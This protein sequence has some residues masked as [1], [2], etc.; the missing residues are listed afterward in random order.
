MTDSLGFTNFRIAKTILLPDGKTHG[1]KKIIKIA[2][3]KNIEKN[4]AH[5][6]G[7]FHNSLGSNLKNKS[8][9]WKVNERRQSS[10]H[11]EH[12][13]KQQRQQP[14]TERATVL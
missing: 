6:S 14:A 7:A 12:S 13:L 11:F 3:Y 8:S 1:L 10:L 9:F 4:Q 5:R 2:Q